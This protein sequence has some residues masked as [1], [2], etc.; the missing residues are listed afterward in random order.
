[1]PDPS[2]TLPD[3]HFDA[4]AA[5]AVA[6]ECRR[7]CAVLEELTG[8]RVRLAGRAREQWEGRNRL[9][10]DDELHSMTVEMQRI[11]DALLGVAGGVAQA[12]DQA[13][14]EQRTRDLARQQAP[15]GSGQ[16]VVPS[17]GGRRLVGL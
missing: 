6:D 7:T 3:V 11:S 15:G 16:D 8:Q 2:A 5:T 10:F 4:A 14:A 12:T 13:Q 17:P 1:V 9:A